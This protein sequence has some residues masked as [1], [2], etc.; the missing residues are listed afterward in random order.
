MELRN[1]SKEELMEYLVNGIPMPETSMINKNTLSFYF[2]ELVHFINL[3]ENDFHARNT[4]TTEIT[5]A[6]GTTDFIVVRR[7]I[8]KLIFY[9][10]PDVVDDIESISPSN[11]SDVVG[12]VY[13]VIVYNAKWEEVSALASQLTPN[14]TKMQ[15]TG[16]A[17]KVNSIEMEN[18]KD[19]VKNNKKYMSYDLK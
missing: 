4:G 17:I 18:L 3:A 2:E 9:M 16:S 11:A 7:F 8:D 5:V 13:G 19:F 1:L 15:T 6:F 14:D 12:L 10:A